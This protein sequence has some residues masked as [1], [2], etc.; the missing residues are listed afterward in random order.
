M[1][2][3]SIHHV[4]IYPAIG[5]AR[6]GNAPVSDHY[7]APEIPGQPADPR[8]GF[9]VGLDK[10]KKQAVRFRVYGLTKDG[11]VVKEL[12]EDNADITWRVHVA[13]RKAAW[14]QFKNALDLPGLALP[15]NFRN[16]NFTGDD[17]KQ[18]IIDPGPRKISGRNQK[19]KK[20]HL[21]GGKF[22][23]KEVPLGEIQ[24]DDKGRLLFFG[25]DGDSANYE[26]KEA[27]TFA[28]NEGWHDDTSDG[29]V[30][31][32]VTVN[33]KTFEAEPAMV[34]VTPPNF[35]QG[36]YGVLTMYDVVY[37]LF[38]QQKWIDAPGRPNFWKH[39][40]PIFE[41]MTQTQWVN[42]GFSFLF[43][44][45]S[46]SDFTAPELK[47][48]LADPS[49]KAKEIREY[50][51][52]WFR[53]P[54]SDDYTPEQIPP[55]YGDAFGDYTNIAE[56]NLPV[57]K[58]QYAW[59]KQWV[60]GNFDTEVPTK[61]QSF[62]EIPVALQPAALTE[63]ALEDCLGGPFHPGIELTWTLRVAS[64][65]KS[66]G[67][68]KESFRL[69]ILPEGVAPG[70]DYGPILAPKI[71]L[72]E[73]G[74]LQANGPGSLTRWMGVPWQTD[75]ASCLSGYDTS[76]YL[77]LPS[78]WAA[79]VPNQVFSKESLERM[80]DGSLNLGQRLKHFDYR[81][82]W[83][84]DFGPVYKKRINSMVQEW[85]TLGIIAKKEVPS[86][87]NPLLPSAVWV[88]TGRDEFDNNDAS[89]QQVKYAENAEAVE[90]KVSARAM[91]PRADKPSRPRP[92]FDRD[93][94]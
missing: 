11:Q 64:M 90:E 6:I 18:L 84:R 27:I 78:F 72:G 12:T 30:R 51:F 37:D 39:I 80:S 63:A 62:D 75:E 5:I 41:R 38:A 10:V 40:Y 42:E 9:K 28:N 77:P 8:G 71:V 46:P 19:G 25:G 32:T 60:V 94:R 93:E 7:I 45:N 24:T 22:V 17:R 35:G 73:N 1:A 14:Y 26:N 76:T 91:A 74:P 43:G 56:V 69:N 61:Y 59:L 33:G 49:P 13:N 50:Y 21:T 55:F 34:A 36:L 83:L 4:A 89:F 82:D 68:W 3:H 81:Q 53:S 20:Y 54:Y 48:Q 66:D 88:E 23:G 15:A 86:D 57:T 87:E 92:L 31:A 85:Y 79:R 2:D 58:T 67:I 44:H 16:A 65:W 29:P 70:D 47:S 52:K